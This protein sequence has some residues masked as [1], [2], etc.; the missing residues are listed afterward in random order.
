[1]AFWQGNS[2]PPIIEHG[3]VIHAITQDGFAVI[4]AVQDGEDSVF[5]GTK[6]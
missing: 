5:A 3:E 2:V 1:M 4:E 6:P